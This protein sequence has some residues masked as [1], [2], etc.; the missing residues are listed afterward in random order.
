MRWGSVFGSNES[1]GFFC[2]KENATLIVPTN[3]DTI[4]FDCSGAAQTFISKTPVFTIYP[5]KS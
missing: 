5:I 4:S 1:G 2:V 3:K